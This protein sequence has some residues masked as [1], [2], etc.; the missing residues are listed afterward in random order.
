MGFSRLDHNIMKKPIGIFDFGIGGLTVAREILMA[1]P[2][3]SLIFLNDNLNL[4][5]GYKPEDVVRKDTVIAVHFLLRH[6]VKALVIA[7]NTATAVSLQYLRENCNIPIV[8]VIE[9]TARGATE[10]TRNG[11]IGVVGTNMTIKSKAYPKILRKLNQSLKIFSQAC[12]LLVPMIEDGI[13]EGDK[14]NRVASEY[15]TRLHTKGIDT[16]IL[17]CTHY[18]LIRSVIESLLPGVKLVDPAPLTAMELRRVLTVNGK[19]NPGLNAPRHVFYAAQL[20]EKTELMTKIAF[21]MDLP[22]TD[23]SFRQAHL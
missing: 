9:P 12:P 1:L 5:A 4:L 18:P 3:E 13:L 22:E 6:N 17:G 8:G 19:L 16:L 14:I 20:N 10:I 2:H 23:L 11:R 21:G 15:L 7:C